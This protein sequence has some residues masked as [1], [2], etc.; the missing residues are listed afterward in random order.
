MSED[1]NPNEPTKDLTADLSDREF[2]ELMRQEFNQRLERLEA[3]TNPLPANYDARFVALEERVKEIRADLKLV[4]EH[5]AHEG[6]ERIEMAERIDA[7][8]NRPS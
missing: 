3:R 8:E 1:N 4:P 6:R 7:L 5:I 2:L